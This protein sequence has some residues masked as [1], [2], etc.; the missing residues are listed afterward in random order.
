MVIYGVVSNTSIGYLFM[1]GVIPGV[2]LGLAQ[3]GVVAAIAKKR[4]F[5]TEPPP[6]RPEAVAT[7]KTALPALLLPVIMLGGIYSGA[8]T[9]TE[10]AAVAACYALLLA[11]FWYRSLGLT[12]FDQ[13][14]DRIVE[15]DGDRRHHHRRR[16]GDEL[17]RRRRADPGGDGRLD[18]RARHVAG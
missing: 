16:P 15:V 2:L 7:V 5:P 8:V 4:N 1:G 6:T 17:D 3:M 12:G 14:A 18:D 9:P 13:G 11:L 10:A